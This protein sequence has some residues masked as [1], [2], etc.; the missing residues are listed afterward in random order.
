[1]RQAQ[2]AALRSQLLEAAFEG[3]SADRPPAK[4]EGEGGRRRGPTLLARML[5]TREEAFWEMYRRGED[6]AAVRSGECGCG[7]AMNAFGGGER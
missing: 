3:G 4:P 5:D 1:E 6:P 7:A 2:D